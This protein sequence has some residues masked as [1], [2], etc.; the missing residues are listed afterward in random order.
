METWE[1]TKD[2]H[3]TG[4]IW[5]ANTKVYDLNQRT[6]QALNNPA[7]VYATFE[8]AGANLLSEGD[9]LFAAVRTA[10]EE[11]A[12][13]LTAPATHTRRTEGLPGVS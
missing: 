7:I 11:F 4:E 3:C 13:A 10:V 1:E 5:K 6:M 9:L 2:T 8:Q 12:E